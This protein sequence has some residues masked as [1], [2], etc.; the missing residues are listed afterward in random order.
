MKRIAM[1][2]LIGLMSS[3][4]LGVFKV[5]ADLEVSAS[6]Q[7]RAT[8]DFHA[9]LAAHGAWIEVGRYGPCW[10]PTN[11]GGAGPQKVVI[12]EGPG[13]NAIAKATGKKLQPISIR[14]AARQTPVPA[15]AT[16]KMNESRK[17]QASAGGQDEKGS[18]KDR[19]TDRNEKPPP[20]G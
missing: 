17:E 14:E 13:L 9:P 3:T 19:K 5:L 8:A 18:L 4:S 15:E 1:C 11:L 12:N 20:A 2:L 16:R 7:I 10:R 6:V